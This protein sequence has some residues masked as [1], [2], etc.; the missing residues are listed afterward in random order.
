MRKKRTAV[1]LKDSGGDKNGNELSD[2]VD[3]DK[4]NKANEANEVDEKREED[5]VCRILEG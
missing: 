5:E 4:V 1:N 2:N 3:D